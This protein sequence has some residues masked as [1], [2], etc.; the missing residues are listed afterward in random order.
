[1]RVHFEGFANMR[2]PERWF[3][4]S[5]L[6]R[7]SLHN[8]YGD[9]RTW[10]RQVCKTL[11]RSPQLE[12]LSLSVDTDATSRLSMLGTNDECDREQMFA[13][14]CKEYAALAGRPLGLKS[15]QLGRGILFP[16]LPALD[17]AFAPDVLESVH[18]NRDTSDQPI[19]RLLLT[20]TVT[21]KL[22]EIS[23][24]EATADEMDELLSNRKSPLQ[25]VRLND[26]CHERADGCSP[27]PLERIG[28]DESLKI[29]MLMFPAVD[30]SAKAGGLSALRHNHWITALAFELRWAAL[31]GFDVFQE[32]VAPAIETLATM[33]SLKYLW[34][35]AENPD[36]VLPTPLVE[37]L[38]RVCPRL[39]YLR[40]DKKAWRVRRWE[41]EAEARGLL[42]PLDEWEDE[43]E[44]PQF[45]HVPDL[46]RGGVM[47]H[48]DWDRGVL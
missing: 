16:D 13:W 37:R 42:E 19:P 5:G 7:L 40:V 48:V 28:S 24:G 12:H 29:P 39:L 15:V 18:F 14:I 30:W 34:I 44:G 27:S 22:E 8:M 45:F 43:V 2:H 1:M 26:Y 20:A 6:R 38:A 25:A 41:P 33:G 4:F 23:M 46:P 31:G 36:I 17:G 9:V 35:V 32:Y 3:A 21:P 10:R 11:L 47:D